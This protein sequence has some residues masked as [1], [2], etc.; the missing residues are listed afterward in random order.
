M[1]EARATEAN[2]RRKNNINKTTKHLSMGE[3]AKKKNI[4]EGRERFQH[5]EKVC[6]LFSV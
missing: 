2:I 6:V 4:E 3:E 1:N 5:T